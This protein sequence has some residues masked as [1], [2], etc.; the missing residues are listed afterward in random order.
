VIT[1]DVPEHG[2]GSLN[3][4]IYDLRGRIIRTLVSGNLEPGKQMVHWDGKDERGHSVPS[5]LYLYRLETPDYTS[6]RRMLLVR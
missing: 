5:G 6:T 2:G 4:K 1:F 3:L